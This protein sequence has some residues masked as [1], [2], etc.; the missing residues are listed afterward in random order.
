MHSFNCMYDTELPDIFLVLHGVGVV[1]G[2]AHY[3]NNLVVTQNCTV[4][5]NFRGDKPRIGKNVIIYPNSSIIGN[6]LIGNNCCVSNNTFINDETVCDNKLIFGK[7]PNLS[8]KDNR[9][10]RLDRF[11]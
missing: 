10:D 5:S 9:I 1:L 2:K 8:Y 6:S 11:F 3:E 4:G 7:S